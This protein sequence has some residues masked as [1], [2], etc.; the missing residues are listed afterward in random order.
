[1]CLCVYVWDA[2]AKGFKVCEVLKSVITNGCWRDKRGLREILLVRPQF[3]RM[4]GLVK[5]CG[6]VGK[7]I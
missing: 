4:N 2:C 7:K 3:F 5:S 6:Y 1:M